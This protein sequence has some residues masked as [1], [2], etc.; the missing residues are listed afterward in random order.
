MTSFM[1][2]LDRDEI[3]SCEYGSKIFNLDSGY[4]GNPEVN[5]QYFNVTTKEF[6]CDTV[7]CIA[8]FCVANAVDW[9]DNLWKKA[10]GFNSNHHDL[11]ETIACS[12]LNIPIQVGKKIFYGDNGS[13]WVLFAQELTNIKEFK[14]LQYDEDYCNDDE[15]AVELN[16]ISP[17][18][19]VKA[20]TLIKDKDI[21][22]QQKYN[23]NPFMSKK[24]RDRKVEE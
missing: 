24:L 15:S 7:G 16:S 18:A 11:Y 10:T 9:N 17:K 13:I 6:N 12:F 19:A 2:I 21:Y 23:Y 20:L 22:F 14:D 5:D 1:G 4:I 3:R 8:G